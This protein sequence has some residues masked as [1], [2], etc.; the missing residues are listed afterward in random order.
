M[1]NNLKRIKKCCIAFEPYRRVAKIVDGVP[2][3]MDSEGR[4]NLRTIMPAVK[5]CPYC[6]IAIKL[7]EFDV[8]EP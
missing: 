3:L 1:E 4:R 2:V 7:E 8:P 5:Y 6:G